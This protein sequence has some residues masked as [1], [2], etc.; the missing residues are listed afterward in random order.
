MN[1]YFLDISGNYFLLALLFIVSIAIS[2]FSY[3]NTIPV[4]D[5]SSKIALI[6][7]R[8]IALCLIIF[9][10]FEPVFTK[11][12]V[13]K[14]SAQLAVL[15]DDTQSLSIK[16]KNNTKEQYRKLL[17][18]INFSKL[19]TNVV[20]YKFSDK[21]F[22][23]N[24]FNFDSLKLKGTAT[25]ISQALYHITSKAE[26]NNTRAILLITDG[27][28]NTGSNPIFEAEN[29]ANPVY[30]IG[31]GDTNEAKDIS[32]ISLLTNEIAYID[33]SIPIN[34]NFKSNG[35]SNK[36]IKLTLFDNKT[37][38]AEQNFT[39][40]EETKNYAANFEYKPTIEGIHKI[41]AKITELDGEITTKNNIL[42]TFIKVLKNK[43]VIAMFAG[44][45][46]PDFAFIKRTLKEEKGIEI[47][48][49]VQKYSSEFY[50]N[51]TEQQLSN[52][53]MFIFN[54]F[55]ISST[56]NQ[57]LNIINTELNKGKPLFFVA[58]L[59]TDYSKLK[60]IQD[61]LPFTLLSTKQREFTIVPNINIKA[62]SNPLLRVTGTDSDIDLWN[63][64]PP[65]FKTETFVKVKPESEVISTI[66]VNNIALNDP[67][68]ITRDF[69]NKKTVAI[70]GYGLYRW[71]LQ[72]YANELAKGLKDTPDLFATLINNTFRWL[73]IYEKHKTV[74]V[75]TTKKHYNQNEKVEFLAEVYDKAFVP[76]DNAEVSIDIKSTDET[77]NILLTSIGSGRYYGI[78]EGLS[79]GDY[80][81]DANVKDESRK[82]GS[83][84][85]RFTIGE[86]S[87]EFQNLKQNTDLLNTIAYRTNGKFYNANNKKEIENIID[88]IIK[89]DNFKTK[90]ITLRN[91]LH[92]WN[93]IWL[94]L[95]AIFCL[96]I[97]WFLRKRKGL[98]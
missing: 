21:T 32:I 55:P 42:S 8:S 41:T 86:I 53:D 40:S 90:P 11:I 44:S 49:F 79:K 76:I 89:N 73:S 84:N 20:F 88:D 82:I 54:N 3:R 26:E 94:L 56:P 23:I 1:S 61:H 71:K 17:S 19:D 29:F 87:I 22:L 48:E 38:I 35:F 65:L 36:N 91:E 30:T 59:T 7:L 85:G 63:N 92:I 68:I 52:V 18:N 12:N 46:N 28:F 69:Q 37:K 47:K 34:I 43:R 64:L 2:I 25:D 96:A 39:L 93:W 62:L 5:K 57:I 24:N 45:P 33:N 77:R 97:E 80:Y 4:I 70:L 9:A 13:L 14:K 31:I 51:P 98:L 66:K 75:R 10:I 50:I 6:T 15:L 60:I 67:L 83:D 27:A 16:S 72:G 74:N 81:F 58:G 95:I 78:V